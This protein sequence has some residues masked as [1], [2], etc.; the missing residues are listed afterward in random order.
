MAMQPSTMQAQV[1]TQQGETI[2]LAQVR[3]V[4]LEDGWH[5]IDDLEL[6]YTG[7]SGQQKNVP[8]T[9]ILGFSDQLQ[10]QD[11]SSGNRGT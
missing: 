5:S 2:G 1:T 3:A 6:S 4:K 10:P 9:R 8:F 7:K 11:D